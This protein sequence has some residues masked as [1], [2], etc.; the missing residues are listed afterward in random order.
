M[1]KNKEDMGPLNESIHGLQT[2][3]AHQRVVEL[4]GADVIRRNVSRRQRFGDLSH[5][6][7]LICRDTWSSGLCRTAN[8]RARTHTHTLHKILW[9][10]I[11]LIKKRNKPDR[12]PA[13]V[14]RSE[15]SSTALLRRW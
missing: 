6:A 1:K 5:D 8:A 9:F 10:L 12:I 2:V 7:A 13:V 3:F 4:E 14:R 15:P 11:T